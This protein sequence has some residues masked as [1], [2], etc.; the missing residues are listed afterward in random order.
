[1]EVE[2]AVC[3]HIKGVL[4]GCIIAHHRLEGSVLLLRLSAFSPFEGE[5]CCQEPNVSRSFQQEARRGATSP[6][7]MAGPSLPNLDGVYKEQS[8]NRTFM[9]T[10]TETCNPVPT[11]TI[12]HSPSKHPSK[13]WPPPLNSQSWQR[14]TAAAILH[15]KPR[16]PHNAHQPT[17]P[18]IFSR[19]ILSALFFL[20]SEF[21][22]GALIPNLKL[23]HLPFASRWK[24]WESPRTDLNLIV[25]KANVLEIFHVGTHPERP[26]VLY[27]HYAHGLP[28]QRQI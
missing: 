2:D 22:F 15:P 17:Q 5:G 11:S 23:L 9:K 25:T 27:K 19:C 24:Q 8:G 4:Y 20:C 28:S 12:E 13:W 6:R 21:F 16:P 26:L 10:R 18:S 3:G 14:Q 7:P 1:M